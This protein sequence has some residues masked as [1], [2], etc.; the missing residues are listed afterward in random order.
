[1]QYSLLMITGKEFKDIRLKLGLSM[2]KMGLEI[3]KGKVMI[4]KYETER[5]KIPFAVEKCMKN[6]DFKKRKS[7]KIRDK[8]KKISEILKD[9]EYKAYRSP[10]IPNNNIICLEFDKIRIEFENP[11]SDIVV[12]I[13]MFIDEFSIPLNKEEKILFIQKIRRRISNNSKKEVKILTKSKRDTK[14]EFLLNS[15]NFNNVK[16]K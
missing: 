12:N 1:M 7:K 10:D 13:E 5:V 9:F 14:I 2:Q 4:W 6:F 11:C 15:I 8:I 16:K 3:G